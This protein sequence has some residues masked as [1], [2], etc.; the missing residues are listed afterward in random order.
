[1]DTQGYTLDLFFNH[2]N[3]YLL[4]SDVEYYRA[5]MTGKIPL[6]REDEGLLAVDVQVSVDQIYQFFKQQFKSYDLEVADRLL[7]S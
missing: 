3:Q 7:N 4:N 5:V 2:L 6:D 1:M